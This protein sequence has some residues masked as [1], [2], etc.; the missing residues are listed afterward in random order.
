MNTQT[1]AT[2]NDLIEGSSEAPVALSPRQQH[3]I[4]LYCNVGSKTFGN[5]YKSATNAGY[6]N[7]TA[8][9]LMHLRPQWLSDSIG[10][11]QGMEP[12]HLILKLTQIINNPREK[13]QHKLKAIDML[14][15]HNRMY[16]DVRQN[17]IQINIQDVLA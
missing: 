6:S 14:M 12:E 2:Q 13:T 15:R 1:L 7:L 11:L 8:R 17:N 5:C 10:Q 3:F 9:N 16:G 4:D